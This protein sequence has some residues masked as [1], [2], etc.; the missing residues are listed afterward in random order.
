MPHFYF[1]LK[2]CD[3]LSATHFRV[4]NICFAHVIVFRTNFYSIPSSLVFSIASIL[5]L[6]SDFAQWYCPSFFLT[7]LISGRRD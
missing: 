5:K 7:I 1:F 2:E 3:R 4:P 6:L